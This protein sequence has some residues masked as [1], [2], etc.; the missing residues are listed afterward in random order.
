MSGAL[1]AL[2]DMLRARALGYTRDVYHG[3]RHAA[4]IDR[5]MLQPDRGQRDFGIHV[6]DTPQ[7]AYGALWRYAQ[8]KYAL[9]APYD[10]PTHNWINKAPLTDEERDL[11]RSAGH[12]RSQAELDYNRAQGYALMPLR[13]RARGMVT[14]PDIGRWDHPGNWLENAVLHA[15]ADGQSARKLSMVFSPQRARVVPRPGT[16][17]SQGMWNDLTDAAWDYGYGNRR[18]WLPDEADAGWQRDV[19]DIS[20]RHGVDVWRY[21]NTTEPRPR[22]SLPGWEQARLTTT[23]DWSYMVLDPDAL[24]L[25]WAAFAPEMQGSGLLTKRRGGLA[26]ATANR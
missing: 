5:F 24:R 19:Q 23:P 21:L 20:A 7:T 1:Q 18:R 17:M 15:D 16:R 8:R 25:R 14:V 2:R 26:S 3:T 13:M 22:R 9:S 10:V 6:A 11:L 12:A 4:E